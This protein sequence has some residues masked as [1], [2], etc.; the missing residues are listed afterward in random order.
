MEYLPDVS[1]TL[2]LPVCRAALLAVSSDLT[3]SKYKSFLLHP[4]TFPNVLSLKWFLQS[5]VKAVTIQN[6]N[7]CMI[8]GGCQGPYC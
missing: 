1:H 7:Y 8:L 4:A 6:N 5:D 3:D 2:C